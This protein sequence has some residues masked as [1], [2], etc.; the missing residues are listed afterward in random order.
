MIRILQVIGSMNRGGAENMIM[1]LYRQID[2][3][4]V[5]FDFVENCADRAAFDDEIEALGGRIYRC[6]HYNGKNHFAY[7]QWWKRFFAEHAQEYPIVHGHLGSTAAIYL[8]AARKSGCFTV[9]HSHS[10]GGTKSLRERLYQLYAYPTRFVAEYFLACGQAA[11]EDR[12]GRAIAADMTRCHIIPNAIDTDRFAFNTLVRERVRETL[13][14]GDGVVIGHVGRFSPEK[15]HRF[16]LEIFREI[17]EREPRARLLLVGDGELRGELEEQIESCGLQGKVVMTGLQS[18]V[19]PYYQAMDVFV[20]PSLYEGLPVTMVEAQTSGL[21]CVISDK[22]PLESAL[23]EELVTVRA[24]SE[25]AAAWA[26]HVLERAKT[27]R[28]DHSDVIRQRGYDI[29]ETAKWLEEFYLDAYE[30]NK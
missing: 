28:L 19:T 10:S 15:N 18:D 3:T 21:P 12:Y 24:L 20:F 11:A 9:A 17:T 29:A 26:E 23:T 16:L 14:L 27:P 22:V 7:V 5:Q 6:P 13:G 1:N 4:K 25:S 30:W 2:R 8:A